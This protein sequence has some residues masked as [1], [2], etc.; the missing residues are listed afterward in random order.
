M[1][2]PLHMGSLCKGMLTCHWHHARFDVDS[3]GTLD[4]WADDVPSYEVKIEDGE[5]WINRQRDFSDPVD[6]YKKCLQ[7]GL[8]QNLSIVIAKAVVGLVKLKVPETEIIEIGIKYGTQYRKQGWG[9]GLTI[10]TAMANILPKLDE[11]GKIQALYQGLLHVA[12][13]CRGQE[14]YHRIGSL[15]GYQGNLQRLALWYRDCLEVRDTRG[16]ERVL[17][18]AIQ[19]GME[20]SDL[21]K[22]MMTAVSDHFYLDGGHTLDFHNKAFEALHLL[23]N[24]YQEQILPSLTPLFANATR[25][26][27]LHRWQSPVD[28]VMPIEEVFERISEFPDSY[29][30]FLG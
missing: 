17:L 26:E 16:A 19:G 29:G 28:L 22:M 18:T 8:E 21:S 11:P 20:I 1:G 25:S 10:L 4:P 14:P 13:D 30:V 27:E 23:G 24:Y 7:K 15:Q 5:V 6:E 3:G 12:R 9:S 2:F